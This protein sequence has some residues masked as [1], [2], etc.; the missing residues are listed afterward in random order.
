MP[1]I[2]EDSAAAQITRLQNGVISPHLLRPCTIGDGI[3]PLPTD[4]FDLEEEFLKASKGGRI[5]HFIPASGAAT[6]MGLGDL[7]KALAPFHRYGSRT[8]TPI[9]EHVREAAA[10][11]GQGVESR[12]HFTISP[13]HEVLFQRHVEETLKVL[14]VE[15]IKAEVTFSTQDPATQTLALDETGEPFRDASGNL[16]LRPGGHGALLSNL[17][18]CDAEFVWIHNV[19]N[20]AVESHR[21]KDRRVHR[22]LA[23]KLI[24]MARERT[25][26][27]GPLRV[28]GMVPNT[29][30]PGGGPFWISTADGEKIRI[31]ESAEVNGSDLSQK[32]I[33]NAATHFNPVDMICTL[34]EPSGKPYR[35]HDFSDP[36]ACLITKKI[37]EGRSITALEW[38]GL[39]N[40]GMAG[41]DTVCVEIPLSMFTPVKTM[42]DL[43]RPEHQG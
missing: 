19:D 16:L 4:L 14:R 35:L 26:N 34:R 37:H 8:V 25:V 20:I 23:G 5:I 40:G 31:V 43:Q 1:G 27:S 3:I 28:C 21:A 42:A 12:L 36:N 11:A 10:L 15:G 7:P 13:E 30:E 22:A 24:R 39:W 29:G 32:K 9:E 38:P 17:E 6:R 33:F 41:W 2:S 18:S